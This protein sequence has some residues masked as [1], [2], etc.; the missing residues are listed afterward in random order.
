MEEEEEEQWTPKQQP[1]AS[2]PL[3]TSSPPLQQQS[4]QRQEHDDDENDAKEHLHVSP[5]ELE[6]TGNHIIPITSTLHIVT[7]DEDTPRGTWPVFRLMVSFLDN[8]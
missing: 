8:V 5:S 6:F 3:V 2:L 1:Q 4:D 7:P